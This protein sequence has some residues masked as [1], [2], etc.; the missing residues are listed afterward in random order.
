MPGLLTEV[1]DPLF[2]ERIDALNVVVLITDGFP[3]LG[4]DLSATL[5]VAFQQARLA[6]FVV[7]VT[8]GCSETLAQGIA[9]V[10]KKVRYAMS[11]TLKS[12]QFSFFRRD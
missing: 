9:S 7:C 6:V 8:P 2:G 10:P 3:E 12:N 1:F 11:S 5:S 4:S